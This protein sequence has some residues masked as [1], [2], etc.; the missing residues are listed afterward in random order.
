MIVAETL[1]IRR[2]RGI[3]IAS[4]LM[5]LGVGLLVV[6]IPELYRLGHPGTEFAGGQRGLQRVSI[7]L[8]FLGSMAAMIIGASAGTV[9]LTSG[10]FRDLVATGRSRWALFA[11]RVPGALLYWLPLVTGSYIVVALLDV[12]FS[13]HGAHACNRGVL[14]GSACSYF[15]GTVPP[16]S[17]FVSWYLWILLY[18]CFT[19]LISIGLASL[20]GSRAITLGVLIPFQLL[21]AAALATISQLGG[22]RQLLYTQ[23]LSFLAPSVGPSDG[24]RHAFGPA[25]TTSLPMAWFVLALWVVVLLGAGAWRTARRDV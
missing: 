13:N 14:A 25:V 4:I 3:V 17:Q 6:V 24:P 12:W 5:T 7:F 18:T 21:V 10:I 22:L 19:L 20:V 9:D 8:A 11:A 2:S 23:S 15:G 1:K 16:T